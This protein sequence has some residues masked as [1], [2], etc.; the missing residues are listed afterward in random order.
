MIIAELVVVCDQSIVLVEDVDQE[1]KLLVVLRWQ[2]F[3][4]ILQ[5]VQVLYCFLTGLLLRHLLFE[6]F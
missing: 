2:W 3:Y 4:V 5:K 1:E 6:V